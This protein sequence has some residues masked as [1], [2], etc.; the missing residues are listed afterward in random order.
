MNALRDQPI[1]KTIRQNNSPTILFTIPASHPMH[2]TH[3]EREG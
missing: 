1:A 3:R 2:G